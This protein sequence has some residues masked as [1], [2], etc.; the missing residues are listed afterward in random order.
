MNKGYMERKEER[1]GT[2][3]G[4]N[5]ELTWQ[6]LQLCGHHGDLMKSFLCLLASFK[7]IIAVLTCSPRKPNEQWK[8]SYIFILFHCSYWQH[9]L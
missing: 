9:S 3:G 6:V 8:R 7:K 4:V 5:K 1:W 2:G